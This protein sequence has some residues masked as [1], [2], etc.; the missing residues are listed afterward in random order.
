M[1]VLSLFDGMSC[2]RIALEKSGIEVEKYYASEIDKY[3]EAVSRY[4]YPDIVR[5]GDVTKWREWDIDFS[6]VD[7]LLAGFPCQA[8]SMAGKQK[9]DADPRGALVHDLLDIWAE[10]KKHNPDVKFLFE[11]VKMKKEFIQYINGLFGCEPVEINS[12]LVSAQNR[13][14]LYWCNWD[15]EQ[16]KDKGIH[17]EDILLNGGYVKITKKGREYMDRVVSGGRTHWDFA[18]HSDTENGKSQVVAANFFK[19]VPYNV[20]VDRRNA[21]CSHFECDFHDYAEMCAECIENDSGQYENY[22]TSVVRY[23]DT[24]ECERLQTV[25]DDYTA[26]GVFADGKEKPISNTQRY[27]MVGNGWTVDVISHILSFID[28]KSVFSLTNE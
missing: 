17:I 9:G 13:K 19:G 2:G 27:K 20:L 6:E 15:V 16:P 12:A 21:R 5:L 18:H 14:R 24:M 28:K 10:C 26:R 4:N 23:F 25:P 7:L 8:W 11:N 1:K 22:Q 3:A